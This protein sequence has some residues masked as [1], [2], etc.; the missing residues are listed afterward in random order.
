MFIGVL[1]YFGKHRAFVNALTDRY[2]TPIV[3]MKQQV[4]TE[5]K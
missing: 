2:I 1:L 3:Y 4:N 5:V